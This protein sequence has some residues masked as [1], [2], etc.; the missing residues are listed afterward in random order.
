VK[1]V[2]NL[3]FPKR[4]RHYLNIWMTVVFTRTVPRRQLSRFSGAAEE[5][6]ESS[7]DI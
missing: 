3:R 6:H 4:A 1:T 5:N 7:R 2:M